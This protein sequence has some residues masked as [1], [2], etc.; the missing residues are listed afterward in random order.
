MK[1]AID[2]VGLG[3]SDL[4]RGRVQYLNSHGLSG[5]FVIFY[6]FQY[7]WFYHTSTN[8]AANIFFMLFIY[9]PLR[10]GY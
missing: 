5:S 8:L 2:P 7:I 6:F 3:L 9:C 1:I 4:K 10:M